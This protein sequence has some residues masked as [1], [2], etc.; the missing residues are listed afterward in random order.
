FLQKL[1]PLFPSNCN[2]SMS[3]VRA[4]GAAIEMTSVKRA[5]GAA[6]VATVVM[7]R[8]RTVSRRSRVAGRTGIAS[9]TPQAEPRSGFS[10]RNP[11]PQAWDVGTPSPAA[12]PGTG[13]NPNQ[14][15]HDS[16]NKNAREFHKR[17]TL[18]TKRP[19]ARANASSITN[20]CA[21]LKVYL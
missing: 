17:S 21:F 14:R 3:A 4:I 16:D 11:V 9:A 6:V 2:A 7:A 18:S 5:V 12:R 15:D 10:S 8:F 13:G 19:Y 20:R 1:F